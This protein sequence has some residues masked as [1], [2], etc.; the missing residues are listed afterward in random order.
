MVYE[1]S[2]LPLNITSPIPLFT[3]VLIANKEF[4]G[5]AEFLTLQVAH[6]KQKFDAMFLPEKK[7]SANRRSIADPSTA[8]S[9]NALISLSSSSLSIPPAL[10][11][12]ITSDSAWLTRRSSS[13]NN[14]EMTGRKRRDVIE[15]DSQHHRRQKR[16]FRRAA[17]SK[18]DQF[19][20]LWNSTVSSM[21]GSMK[22]GYSFTT[23]FIGAILAFVAFAIA[24]LEYYFNQKDMR[25]YEDNGK[26]YVLTP[27]IDTLLNTEL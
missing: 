22:K 14:N 10:P 25:E 23:T 15:T 19:E 5:E 2:R 24:C 7:H 16:R 13:T 27:R 12:Q 17:K 26:T 21:I 1:L 11:S 20:N 8:L 9:S 6:N 3:G 18:A 4:H